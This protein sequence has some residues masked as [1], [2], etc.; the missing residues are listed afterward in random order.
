[1]RSPT[2]SPR[3]SPARL[4]LAAST[5][6]QSALVDRTRA[7]RTD[8]TSVSPVA[9]RS[10]TEA[11]RPPTKAGSRTHGGSARDRFDWLE[12]GLLGAAPAPARG[13]A[14]YPAHNQQDDRQGE[15]IADVGDQRCSRR[16]EPNACDHKAQK[17]DQHRPALPGDR[18]SPPPSKAFRREPV[19]LP[20]PVEEGERKPLRLPFIGVSSQTVR[21]TRGDV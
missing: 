13:L 14:F 8:A 20:A 16:K 9:R 19:S 1:M 2:A 4:Q 6:T 3:L 21:H 18:R 15:D 5:Q 17:G 12:S 11:G 10:T 7:P